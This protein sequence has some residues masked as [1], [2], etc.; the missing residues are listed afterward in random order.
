MEK[1]YSYASLIK[2]KKKRVIRIVGYPNI[3][4]MY[5]DGVG[6]RIVNGTVFQ[7]NLSKKY[8]ARIISSDR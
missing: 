3:K 6:R 8:I 1:E 2:M 5:R 4:S 7:D